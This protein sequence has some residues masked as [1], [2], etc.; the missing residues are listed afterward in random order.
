MQGRT[1]ILVSHHVQLCAPGAAFIV[2]LDNGRVQFQGNRDQFHSSGVM[3][4][5]VQSTT[6]NEEEQT[7]VAMEKVPGDQQPAEGSDDSQS[8]VVP[9][10]T[11]GKKEKSAPRKLIEEEARAV[12]RVARD[13]WA[14]Y[15]KAC[16]G[17]PYWTLFIFVFV[18]AALGPVLENGWVGYW[19][20]GDESKSA[21]YYITI[22]AIVRLRDIVTLF[23]DSVP[24][25]LRLLVRS[26][27]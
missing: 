24:F 18:I 3:S 27:S 19:S 21:V 10:P 25:S 4:G 2:A 11:A 9:S 1:V 8:T 17:A 14:T 12:G 20:R 22:Y 23:S 15:I 26:A 13:V 6:A 5:L 7:E 16:G